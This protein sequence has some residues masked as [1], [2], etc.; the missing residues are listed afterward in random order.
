M[1]RS[2]SATGAR[3]LQLHL[4]QLKHWIG[5]QQGHLLPL[6]CISGV[7][8]EVDMFFRWSAFAGVTLACLSTTG[9]V[10]EMHGVPLSDTIFV[11]WSG[12]L[13]QSTLPDNSTLSE[14]LAQTFSE[15]VNSASVQ[16]AFIPRFNC[17][18]I[19]SILVS[20]ETVADISADVPVRLTIDK[21]DMD[22][23][24]MVDETASSRQYSYNGN[25][26]EQEKLREMLDAAS[27]VSMSWELAADDTSEDSSPATSPTVMFSLLGSRLSTQAVE[28]L[29]FKHEPIPY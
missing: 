19:F 6:H 9:A 20:K 23:P 27:R 18:P 21:V 12:A 1:L 13:D 11:K 25:H 15:N 26:E 3:A 7:P 5:C 10:A 14:Y 22:F 24:A 8:N 29:C 17:T 4:S 16:L 2:S 28:S